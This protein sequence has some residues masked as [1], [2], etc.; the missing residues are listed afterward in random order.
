VT[1]FEGVEELQGAVGRH[2]G[3]SE[4]VTLTQE[5]V[6]AFDVATGSRSDNRGTVPP[7]L[8][9]SL[10]N[11]LL[12]QILE[13]HNISMGVNYGAG[14]V[15]FPAPVPIGS[16]VRGGAELVAAD[17]VAGGVQTTIV[18]TVEI[19]NADEPACVI[20]SLSRWLA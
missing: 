3:F 20:E 6:D 18:I 13:V 4:W 5:R 1:V 9:L 2:L 11:F 14:R 10:S 7:Y 15:H 8:T 19:D 17:P 12:P 16:R